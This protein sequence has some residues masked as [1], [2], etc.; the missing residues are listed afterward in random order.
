[1]LK[2]QNQIDNSLKNII[3]QPKDETFTNCCNNPAWNQTL[4]KPGNAYVMG[5]PSVCDNFQISDCGS[6]VE[7]FP[8]LLNPNLPLERSD[9]DFSRLFEES[10]EVDPIN[11]TPTPTPKTGQGGTVPFIPFTN[12]ILKTPES[13]TIIQTPGVKGF[14]LDPKLLFLGLGIILF[15]GLQK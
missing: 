4:Q 14:N 8:L 2:Y 11:G 9:E 7:K 6:F 3:E 13:R 15:L 10:N 5:Y 1:M 12:R